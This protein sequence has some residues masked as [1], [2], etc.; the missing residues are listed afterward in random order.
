MSLHIVT[1]SPKLRYME[2][3]VNLNIQGQLQFISYLA[4]FHQ[5]LIG[6]EVSHHEL[7]RN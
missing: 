4:Y 1:L 6:V 3:I 5:Y 2:D 7:K